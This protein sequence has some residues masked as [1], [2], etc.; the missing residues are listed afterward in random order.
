MRH[1]LIHNLG[2]MYS[3]G[4]ALVVKEVRENGPYTQAFFSYF[5]DIEI[6]PGQSLNDAVINSNT[7]DNWCG[8]YARGRDKSPELVDEFLDQVLRK[9]PDLTGLEAKTNRKSVEIPA[10]DVEI[11]SSYG[12]LREIVKDHSG[13]RLE[14]LLRRMRQ[15]AR[16]QTGYHVGGHQGIGT[17]GT[18]PY[19]LSG[20]S[21]GG[22]RV[23]GRSMHQ[24]ARMVLDDPRY[25]PVD[26][27]ALL[28]DDNVDAALAALQGVTEHS[29]RLEL[30]IRKT[31][32]QGVKRG[33]IFLPEFRTE[34]DERLN[35]MLFI[36]NGG[37]SMEPYIDMVRSLFK[38]MKT[39]F[40]HDL[41]TFYF[42]NIFGEYVHGDERRREDP[43]ALDSLLKL[44]KHQRVFIIGDAS[45][46]PYELTESLAGMSGWDYLK[47]MAAAFPR[48]AWLNP[49][50]E[51]EWEYTQTLG[52]IGAIVEMFPL[53][54]KG[55][56]RAI[57]YMNRVH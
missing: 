49:K 12:E 41:R 1:G 48:I 22:I 47:Q 4:R 31:I 29:A 36:D 57:T 16:T 30:D 23:G 25:F 18:A 51:E 9:S 42:H 27:D 52:D 19:G 53:S 35:V 26:L 7:F 10:V 46:A 11:E 44:G 20:R 5:L 17:M 50:Q 24:R 39:R 8:L 13:R 43:Y 3:V 54:P 45:M 21:T 2:D 38:K 40:S 14:V 37:W 55:I 32:R 6:Q 33:G 15:L 56:E 34:M 28:S